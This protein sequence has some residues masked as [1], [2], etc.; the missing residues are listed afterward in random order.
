MIENYEKLVGRFFSV[1]SQ[2][3]VFCQITIKKTRNA[4]KH[5]VAYKIFNILIY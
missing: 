1:L 5:K 3:I 2:K 4:Q